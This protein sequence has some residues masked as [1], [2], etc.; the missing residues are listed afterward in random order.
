[1]RSPLLAFLAVV[2]MLACSQAQFSLPSE[3]QYFE[4][5]RSGLNKVLDVLWVIDN[6]GSMATS[7]SNLANNLDSFIAGFVQRQLSFKMAFTTT[8][9]YLSQYSGNWAQSNFRDGGNQ[10]G[11]SGIPIITNTTPNIEDVFLLNARPG[12]DG[13]GDERAFQSMWQTLINPNN[14][15][16]LRPD[17]FFSVIVISDEDDASWDQQSDISGN[18]NDSRLHPI[19]RYVDFLDSYTSSSPLARKYIV[20]T[21]SIMDQACLSQLM[22]SGG[23]QKIG[24]RYMQM[25]DATGGYK[26]SLCSNFADTLNKI[27]GRLLE[28]LTQFPLN[29]IPDVNSIEVWVDGMKVVQ[30]STNGWTYDPAPNAIFF[31]GN[32][33]PGEGQK[34]IINYQPTNPR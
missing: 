32:A 19:S 22:P 14:Q 15:N 5:N 18:P 6:S 13:Y 29:R 4:Q 34:V 2:C 12:T 16:F 28:L 25:S 23:S 24:T 17:S 8:D 10:N 11:H 26:G 3:Q 20:S 27:A 7:Q 33:I 30:S 21:I 1:M 31:H 9:A